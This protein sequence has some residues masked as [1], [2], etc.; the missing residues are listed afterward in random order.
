MLKILKV[1]IIEYLYTAQKVDC[2]ICYTTKSA[3]FLADVCN[4]VEIER[5]L[6]PIEDETFD[7]KSTSTDV[8]ARVDINGLCL[9]TMSKDF[10]S[11]NLHSF[12]YL[13]SKANPVQPAGLCDYRV[14]WSCRVEN[15]DKTCA[16]TP[17]QRNNLRASNTGYIFERSR[18]FWFDA[19]GAF[20]LLIVFV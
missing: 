13:L 3:K 4:N 10:R 5:K 12:R 17:S 1:P 2:P 6:Q 19:H 16:Q 20:H 14:S 7:K 8:E 9:E 15:Q 11:E 18:S